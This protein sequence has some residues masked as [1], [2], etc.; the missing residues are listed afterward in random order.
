MGFALVITLIM[1]VLAGITV[2]ALLSSASADLSTASSVNKRARAEMAAQSGLAAALNALVGANGPTDFRFITA[3][4]DDGKPVLIPLSYDAVTGTTSLDT[5]NKRLLYSTGGS[6]ATLTLSTTANPKPT[7]TPGYVSITAKISGINQEIERYAFY[8][9]ETGSRQNLSV[10]GGTDRSFARDPNEL[11]LVTATAAPIPFSTTQVATLTS[12]RPLLFTA[13]T[14]NTVLSADPVTPVVDNYSYTTG[15]SVIDVTPEGKQKVNLTKLKSYVDSLSVDQT[16]HN[17]RANLVDRLLGLLPSQSSD[18]GGGDLSILLKLS[19]YTQTQSRQIVA[20]LLDYLDSDLIP[21]TDNIDNPTYFGVEGSANGS[22]AVVGHPYINFVGTGLVFNRSSSPPGA[23]NST[24]VLCFIGLVNPWGQPTKDWSTF[25]VQPEIEI[26]IGGTSSGGNLGDKAGAYFLSTFSTSNY[27][28]LGDDHLLDYPTGT[29]AAQAGFLFPHTVAGTAGQYSNFNDLLGGKGQ[30]PPGMTFSSLTFTIKKLRLKYTGTDGRSGYV[31]V[32]DGLKAISQPM[33][34]S[35]VN[36]GTASGA[37]TYRL[38]QTGSA[39]KTD[40][41]LNGDA[42]LNI[43]WHKWL[44]SKSTAPASADPVAPPAPNP[45]TNVNVFTGIDSNNYDFA[46]SA[47]SVTDHT[48]Y[49]KAD[50]TSN[51]YVKSPPADDTAPRLDSVGELGYLHTGIP[52]ETLRLYVTGSEAGGKQR[53]RELLSYLQSGTFKTSDYGIVPTHAGQTS[54]TNPPRSIAGPLNL[55]TNKRPA[56]QSVFLGATAVVDGDARSRANGGTADPDASTLADQMASNAATTPFSLISDFL[57]LPNVKSVTNA[58]TVDFNREVLARRIAN[59]IG[60][61]STR[62]TV[63]A[64]G[65]ARDKVGSATTTTSA[66][67]LS[68]EVELQTDSTGKPMPKVLST[69]YYTQ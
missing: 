41:H 53:D 60:T 51:F 27:N 57:S 16:T 63:Y 59:V 22:G 29:I 18:W 10:Q 6:T 36:M 31:Q 30:Q 38:G 12:Q 5:A 43:D 9:D 64:R 50:I 40:F 24:R 2:V 11:P 52:W 54:P 20:N 21:I 3:V 67:N 14:A 37:L 55:N 68:A 1:V 44:L 4:G 66:V 65:E 62:F 23:L 48:W 32:L 19:H 56:L 61:Q 8:V 17:P 45:V 26:Q 15:S 46:G 42:R 28:T 7:R 49:T 39:T 47:P 69:A 25:Y 34:Q 35:T 58:Q 13:P 33:S